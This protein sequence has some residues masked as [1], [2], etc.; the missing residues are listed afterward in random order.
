M[1][2]NNYCT[3]VE[4]LCPLYLKVAGEG[5]G[6]TAPLTL[7]LQPLWLQTCIHGKI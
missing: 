4:G 5:R 3:K 6:V 7:M 1:L 2:D